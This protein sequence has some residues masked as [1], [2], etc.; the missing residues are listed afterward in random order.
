MPADI[1]P[2]ERRTFRFY[3]GEPLAEPSATLAF[4][5]IL[6]TLTDELQVDVNGKV[7]PNERWSLPDIM[8]RQV[9]RVPT[10]GTIGADDSHFWMNGL[11]PRARVGTP[12]RFL[13]RTPH[14]AGLPGMR[15][16]H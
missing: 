7:I 14:H 15:V 9:I 10:G 16:T 8:K 6:M 5:A 3:A 12:P 13:I 4:K 2:A 1:D 11:C